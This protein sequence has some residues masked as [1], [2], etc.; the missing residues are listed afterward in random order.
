M[1]SLG[2]RTGILR[3]VPTYLPLQHL[4]TFTAASIYFIPGE[5]GCWEILEST[6]QITDTK[7]L[8]AFPVKL[9]PEYFL[10]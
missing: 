7:Q 8:T 10:L 4:R 2:L 3:G 5:P 6:L 9:E 1:R